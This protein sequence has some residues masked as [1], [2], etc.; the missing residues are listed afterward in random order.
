MSLADLYDTWSFVE[1][2]IDQ[3][4]WFIRLKGGRYDGVVYRYTEIKLKPEI[5]SISFDYEVTEHGEDN[6]H[7]DNDFNRLLGEILIQV[8]DDAMEA[9]DYILGDK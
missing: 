3:E 9:K 4:H 5:E 6:P 7:G 8:L 1:K 2:D